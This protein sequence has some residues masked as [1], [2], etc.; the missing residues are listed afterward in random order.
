MYVRGALLWPGA[1]AAS[2]PEA[3]QMA[4]IAAQR[5]A[6]DLVVR[7]CRLVHVHVQIYIVITTTAMLP[8]RPC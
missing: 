1:A 7:D 8:Q 6:V 4:L 2:P 3:A 5:D